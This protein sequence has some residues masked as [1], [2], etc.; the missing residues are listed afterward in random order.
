MPD[1]PI[2]VPPLTMR[3]LV[4]Q[5]RTRHCSCRAHTRAPP[6]PPLRLTSHPSPPKSSATAALR[7]PLRCKR[8][9][10]GRRRAIRRMYSPSLSL[11][12]KSSSRGAGG[13]N[14][15]LV[16]AHA[17]VFAAHYAKLPSFSPT[18]PVLP[19]TLSS[20]PTFAI[21]RV[22]M[23]TGCLDT[24]FGSLLLAPSILLVLIILIPGFL[25]CSRDILQPP[26]APPPA[27]SRRLPPLRVRGVM[28]RR[29]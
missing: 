7:S 16:P 11:P 4:P 10:F 25:S 2:R 6:S 17:V 5:H 18:L 15:S 29:C 14:V 19:I 28:S 3:V 8:V 1:P 9:L 27:P 21:L 13:G 24:A 26:Y 22:W 20:P 12:P 23:Y